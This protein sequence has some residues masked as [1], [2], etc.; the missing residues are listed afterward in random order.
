[1]G[2]KW[3]LISQ[4]TIAPGFRP[5][6]LGI[7]PLLAQILVNRGIADFDQARSFLSPSLSHLPDPKA[8]K[9]MDRAI[10]RILKALREEEKIFLYGDYDVDGITSIALLFLFLKSLGA[11]VEFYIPDRLQ[12]GYGLHEEALVWIRR[13][14]TKLL[15]TVD[16]GIHGHGEVRWA[17]ENGMDV[18]ITD[19]HEVPEILPPALAIVNPKQRNCPY[20]FKSLAGVGVVFNLLVALRSALRAEGFWKETGEPNLRRFLDLVALGTIA[21]VVPLNGVN[22][23]FG[24]FGLAELTFTQRPG[25]RALKQVSQLQD[26]PIDPLSICFRLA[27]RMNA[28]GRLHDAHEAVNLLITDDEREAQAIA[29]R[30]DQWNTQRQRIEEKILREARKRLEDSSEGASRKSIVLASPEWHPG[31]IGIVAA[32]LC[33]EY[34]RPTILIA[35]GESLGK[36]SGRAPEFFP[37]YE[38]LQACRSLLEDFGGHEF[39]AGL[40]IRRDRIAEFSQAFEQ[41]AAQRIADETLIPKV[42]IDAL[43]TLEE[44]DEQFVADLD[45]LSPFGP[46]N[47]EPVI[48]A[49]SLT[50]L[51]AWRV[52]NDHLKMRIQQ[53]SAIHEAIGFGMASREASVRGPLRMA[54]TPQVHSYQGRRMLQ[55]RIIDLEPMESAG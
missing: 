45:R 16:C 51:N 10:S 22:R 12:E 38:S 39:A 17:L 42:R 7:S 4:E 44:L 24:K 25:L 36:G 20:P 32:R 48:G 29:C 33:A 1:M 27:P 21:D 30:L 35:L 13:Q 8:L 19:H 41:I 52:G 15:I 6:D 28:A 2:K 49:E 40:V 37:L 46:E 54:F 55:L 47:P 43:A 9:D 23:I 26:T 53:G 31:V 14:G 18:I 3:E 34:Q 11:R 50:V 5:H